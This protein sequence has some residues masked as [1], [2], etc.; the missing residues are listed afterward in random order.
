MAKTFGQF[1]AAVKFGRP[2][3]V[4]VSTATMAKSRHG[5]SPTSQGCNLQYLLQNLT[6]VFKT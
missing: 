5:D 4:Q 1:S 6:I 2:K 3:V